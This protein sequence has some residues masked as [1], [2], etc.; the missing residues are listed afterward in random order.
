MKTADGVAA[1]SSLAIGSLFLLALSCHSCAGVHSQEG[2]GGVQRRLYTQI[3]VGQ[4]E[5]R[6]TDGAQRFVLSRIRSIVG[7][8]PDQIELPSLDRV[9]EPG[10]PSEWPAEYVLGRRY[11]VLCEPEGKG[12][13]KAGTGIMRIVDLDQTL[14][15]RKDAIGMLTPDGKRDMLKEALTRARFDNLLK[16]MSAKAAE[17]KLVM[18]DV[19]LL[20]GEPDV[21]EPSTPAED[22]DG[23][24]TLKYI[25]RTNRLTTILKEDGVAKTTYPIVILKVRK[26]MVTALRVVQRSILEIPSDQIEW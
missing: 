8:A 26:E 7:E 19:S 5:Q 22:A 23:V 17:G 6:T 24:A 4:V 3:Y 14:P 12:G 18:A 20:L 25:M 13:E 9:L 21:I 10:A 2:M 1:K 11:L 15:E 16:L